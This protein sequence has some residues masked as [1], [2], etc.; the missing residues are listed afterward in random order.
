[1]IG[2][3]L[4]EKIVYP[5][6]RNIIENN[7]I[8]FTPSGDLAIG[9][10][11]QVNKY[12]DERSKKPPKVE[13]GENTISRNV[14][15]N[16]AKGTQT[17]P[18]PAN[19]SALYGAVN[20]RLKPEGMSLAYNGNVS[21]VQQMNPNTRTGPGSAQLGTGTTVI[22][23]GINAGRT[24]NRDNPNYQQYVDGEMRLGENEVIFEQGKPMNVIQNGEG[25]ASQSLTTGQV[26][27]SVTKGRVGNIGENE[28]KSSRLRDA[29]NDTQGMQAYMKNLYKD[30]ANPD[31]RMPEW[32]RR[33]AAFLSGSADSMLAY[34]QAEASQNYMRQNGINMAID[35][36]GNPLGEF[37][38]AGLKALKAKGSGNAA[39]Q[40]F[41]QQYGVQTPA[42]AQSPELYDTSS[43][44]NL[45]LAAQTFT[46]PMNMNT[47]MQVPVQGFNLPAEDV[48][49]FSQFVPREPYMRF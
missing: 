5:G 47:T 29:L 2:S 37:S 24:I 41:L 49:E 19:W 43:A 33:G 48:D 39:A 46:A 31:G 40:S 28:I 7:T 4:T 12:I 27:N 15:R 35:A 36:Q 22:P 21:S 6:V 1:M 30:E 13:P 9:N 34:R 17:S 18:S 14:D 26:D 23:T 44:N 3:F 8:R 20:E 38:D 25:V 16:G 45:Q 42:Q 10:R 11:D 32:D